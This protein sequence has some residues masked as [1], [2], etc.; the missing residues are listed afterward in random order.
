[1]KR[2]IPGLIIL[3]CILL[4]VIGCAM[5]NQLFFAKLMGV[6]LVVFTSIALRVWLR[7]SSKLKTTPSIIRLSVNDRYVLNQSCSFYVNL[8][9]SEK[10]I[11]ESKLGVLLSQ[12]SFDADQGESIDTEAC[13]K[14]G[15]LYL[16]VIDSVKTVDFSKRV[17]VFQ[18][19]D[20]PDVKIEKQG[21]KQIVFV[22]VNAISEE[23]KRY[24]SMSE[25]RMNTQSILFPL[26]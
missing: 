20:T 12:V 15:L 18:N 16:L 1:M 25:A 24:T 13:L 22:S 26:F 7:R 4:A 9:N 8:R 21:E 11:I 19:T 2:F 5:T 17:I 6:C 10:K 3:L 14:F 23:L